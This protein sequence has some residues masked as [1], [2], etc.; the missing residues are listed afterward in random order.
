[1]TLNSIYSLT[2]ALHMDLKLSQAL[3]E[4]FVS[5]FVNKNHSNLRMITCQTRKYPDPDPNNK[6]KN[7]HAHEVWTVLSSA[8]FAKKYKAPRDRRSDW[9]VA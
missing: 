7:S 6:N 5:G 9:A 3:K 8:K 1:M 2:I 4:P